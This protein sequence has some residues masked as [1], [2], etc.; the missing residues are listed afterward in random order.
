MAK[1]RNA[2]RAGVFM[3]VS[4]ALIIFVIIA[5]TGAG[6]F[7]ES[8]KTYAIAFDMRDDVGGLR[9]G[10]DVRIGGVKAG[11]VREISV[12]P[13]RNAVI[14]II[15]LPAKFPLAKDAAVRV[16]RGL[17]GSASINIESLGSGPPLA[18]DQYI[19][20]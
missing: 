20:G 4:I 11:S 6:R 7:T 8:F 1:P 17:T 3:V 15:D 12:D 19:I 5:I 18:S 16:Q 13:Q 9:T 14:T 2:L 10:D